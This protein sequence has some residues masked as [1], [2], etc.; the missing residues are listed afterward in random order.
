MVAKGRH[1]KPPMSNSVHVE[2]VMLDDEEQN[3]VLPDVGRDIENELIPNLAED[4]P[5]AFD[6][7]LW[8]DPIVDP[9]AKGKNVETKLPS[10][11]QAG[12][13][14]HPMFVTC[15]LDK[16]HRME[17]RVIEMLAHRDIVEAENLK[18]KEKVD[19]DDKCLLHVK[20]HKNQLIR[21]VLKLQN[22]NHKNEEKVQ[23]L[24]AQVTLMQ[25]KGQSQNLAKGVNIQVFN[26]PMKL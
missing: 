25:F 7:D 22:E 26:A 17:G 15:L 2:T 10:S 6:K 12:D 5:P 1:V 24:N 9:P 8:V 23:E 16:I 14:I 11:Y 19:S 13:L 18:L 21:R 4:S 20:K 3:P